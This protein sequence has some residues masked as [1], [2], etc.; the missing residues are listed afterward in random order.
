MALR[1]QGHGETLSALAFLNVGGIWLYIAT[2]MHVCLGA[3]HG[4]HAHLSR[5]LG[6]TTN[7]ESSLTVVGTLCSNSIYVLLGNVL[8]TLGNFVSSSYA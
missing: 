3:C 5:K 4:G 6:R 1:A 8:P 7:Q 2:H